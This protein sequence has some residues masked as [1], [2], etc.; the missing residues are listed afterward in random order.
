MTSRTMPTT[1]VAVA[2]MSAGLGVKS[3]VIS[4]RS[5]RGRT[6]TPVDRR[7]AASSITGAGRMYVS[8]RASCSMVRP[9]AGS[10]GGSSKETL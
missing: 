8:R 5:G 2:I 3:E 6:P 7:L 1:S 9:F 10:P 4:M